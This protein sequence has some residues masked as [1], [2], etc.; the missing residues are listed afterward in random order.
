MTA[1]T[2]ETIL[3][4]KLD[5]PLAQAY[6]KASLPAYTML[7]CGLGGWQGAERVGEARV[8]S[9][10]LPGNIPGLLPILEEW[11]EDNRLFRFLF[12]ERLFAPA[13]AAHQLFT[14]RQLGNPLHM[15]VKVQA[16]P[17]CLL[18]NE[19]DAPAAWLAEPLLNRLP[20]LVW[21]MGPVTDVRVL[22]AGGNGWQSRVVMLRHAAPCRLSVLDMSLS[23]ELY[24]GDRPAVY[25]R[26]EC[27]G[28]DGFLRVNGIW[29][30]DCLLPRLELHRGATETVQR[31]LRRDFAQV[32]EN[33]VAESLALGRVSNE[34]YRIAASYLEACNLLCPSTPPENGITV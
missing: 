32:Y 8:I 24:R 20:L 11:Q 34:S 12:P 25:D 3:D 28:T 2:F 14:R 31:D 9:A 7:E 13:V 17:D 26:F 30:E 1:A 21:M 23:R 5:R 18:H 33:A 27:T 10:W 29:E 16:H 19:T 22:E 15:M 6:A 4:S